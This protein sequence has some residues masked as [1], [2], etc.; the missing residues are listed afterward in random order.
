MEG[1]TLMRIITIIQARMG[2]SRLPGKVLLKLG[3]KTVFEQV[4]SRVMASR[5]GNDIVLATTVDKRDLPLVNLCSSLGVSVYCGS[6]ND[7]LDRYYQAARLFEADIV[8]RITSDCPV[9]DPKVIDEVISLHLNSGADYTSNTLM[10]LYPDG[11]DTEV[12]T[13]N[14]LKYAWKHAE[15]SSEREHVTPYIKK[16]HELFKF[17][18]L[19]YK[20]DLSKKRW[21]LDDKEDFEFL[22]CIYNHLY[23]ENNLFGMDA[24]LKLLAE[25]PDI[26]MINNHIVRNSGYKKSLK[27]DGAVD[28]GYTKE[29]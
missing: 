14:A 1:E 11:Q 22:T 16:H 21:T 23:S 4:L 26:E 8:V 28:I 15:L 27:N 18:S 7:V 6:E 3:N 29:G 24:I 12:F 9:I 2:S 13:F 20:E 19:E 10:E 5:L 17:S 25:K